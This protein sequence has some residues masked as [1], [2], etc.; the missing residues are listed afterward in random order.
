MTDTANRRREPATVRVAMWSSRHRWPV[1]AAWFLGTI[2]VFVLSALTGGIRAEDANGSP[3]QAQTE[4]AKALAVFDQGGTGTPSEDVLL[5]VTH[6]DLK[7][8]DPA[9]G[10]FVAS[11]I[12]TL[13]GLT[14]TV[15]G[16]TV[17]VFDAIPDPA[18]APPQ[19]GLVAP[20]LSAVR[21]VATMTGDQDT[22]D[23]LLVPV[24][25][26]IA[27]IEADGA[28]KG[29]DVHTLSST[30]TNEDI[31]TLIN[32]SL[33]TT[34][35]TIGLTFIILLLTFGAF[36][37]AIVPLVLAI[38]ALLAAFGIFGVF[39]QAVAPVSPY[40]T[41]LIILIGLAVSVDYSLFMITR[42]RSERRHGRDKLDAIEIASA[43]AGR[44]VFFSG[45]AVM[46]ALAGL[47]IIDVSIFRSMAI[48]TIGVVFVAVIGSLTFLPATLAILGDG[49]NRGRIPF[50]GREREEGSGLWSRLVGGVMRR[51]VPLAIGAIVVLLLLASPA[52]HLRIGITDIT[53]FP[54]RIDGVQ[55]IKLLYA[56]WPQ[57]STQNLQVAVTDYEDPA[58]QAAVTQFQAAA[59]AI[60]G[61]S[62][63]KVTP[64]RDGKVA[65]VSFT[66]AGAGQNDPASQAIV[67]QVRAT[68]V[69]AAFARLPDVK[70]YVTGQAA[71][72][73]DVTRIYVDAIPAVFAFVLGLSF[74]LLLIV[75]HSIV[76]PVKAI[77]LNLLSTAA[78]YGV[79]VAVFQDNILGGR[80]GIE[81]SSVIESWVPIFIFTILFG[82]SMDYHVFI[83]TRV[84][85]A[86]DRGLDSRSAV[87]RGIALTAGTITS[88][89][90]IMVVVFLAFVTIPFAFI[91][92][93][94]LGLA[95]A[96]FIDAT[97]VR[98]VLLPATM[99]VLGDWNWYL[100]S[101]LGWIPRVTIEGEPEPVGDA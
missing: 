74:I 54:D 65:L 70:A 42:F 95:V 66:I 22:V 23:Q 48:G 90:T 80:L 94:G 46:I 77:L 75:F 97:I 35:A 5:V 88:A 25:P 29:F 2:A 14:A 93:L 33:D 20:D 57:G 4:S 60:P 85:E 34:F 55:A 78:A 43:T 45:L 69:P 12:A 1:A 99:A 41:Q 13:K 71:Q 52:I 18:T 86:R 98:S 44:A 61:L 24:R 73:L 67:S 38:T 19:A 59:G 101:F 100:P 82:L 64:S 37:A 58:T 36:V 49:I 81:S 15:N 56:K 32:S 26:A 51:P 40:A 47:F 28:A 50:F 7:V 84:K 9:F 62:D 83:L 16:Q 96:V 87:A 79:V 53:S 39:S 63:P 76:I 91:Q 8:T 31:T 68:T 89:A 6:P 17:P 72:A 10:S 27:T 21:I 3:N 11:S 30:L 92:E